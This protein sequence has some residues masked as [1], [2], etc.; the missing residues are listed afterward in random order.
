[1]K[2]ISKK[3]PF[4]LAGAEFLRR[5]VQDNQKRAA[6]KARR[7]K[8]AIF[9]LLGAAAGGIV[10]AKKRLQ[11]REIPDYSAP[12]TASPTQPEGIKDL[13]KQPEAPNT[14]SRDEAAKSPTDSK[15]TKSKKSQQTAKK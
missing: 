10:V 13:R 11:G 1:M 12:S 14:T 3:T 9:A 4:V 8:L 15:D 5:K 2:L 6:K 7:K